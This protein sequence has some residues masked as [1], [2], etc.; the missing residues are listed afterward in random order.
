M[1]EPRIVFKGRKAIIRVYDDKVEIEKGGFYTATTRTLQISEIIM[2]HY[3]RCGWDSG[4]IEFV[5]DKGQTCTN[6]EDA[7]KNPLAVRFKDSGQ[8]EDASNI[9]DFIKIQQR[10][11]AQTARQAEASHS[12]SP[13]EAIKLYKELLD[14]GI[15][16]QEEFDAK[17]KQL[18]G[19]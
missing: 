9:S 1:G 6:E 17:K 13:I 18:L 4:F 7:E 12:A 16:T 8:F 3:V 2:V 5:T 11:L 14:A 19:L 10:K 15:I